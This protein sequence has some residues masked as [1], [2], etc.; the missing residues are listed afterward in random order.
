MDIW[1]FMDKHFIHI[2]P[3]FLYLGAGLLLDWNKF[4]NHIDFYIHIH[5]EHIMQ[6]WLIVSMVLTY[7]YTTEARRKSR[8]QCILVVSKPVS[9][10]LDY[11][12]I[13]QTFLFN[14]HSTPFFTYRSQK[15]FFMALAREGNELVFVL[16]VFILMVHAL[17]IHSSRLKNS[18]ILQVFHELSRLPRLCLRQIF[19]LLN[20]SG[21]EQDI[22]SVSV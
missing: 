1:I 6:T 18:V 8:C 3:R 12:I 4:F 9:R 14:R 7:N 20:F 13:Y 22:W 19:K 17:V 11:I 16:L 5:V 10:S 15:E 21:F 2:L